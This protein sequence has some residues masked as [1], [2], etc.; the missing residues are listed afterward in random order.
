MGDALRIAGEGDARVL[1]AP[2][3]NEL[4]TV[5]A[6][7]LHPDA[8]ILLKASRGITLERMVPLLTDWSRS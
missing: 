8:V 1:A 4:W 5:L 2:D 3:V 7:R 6:P